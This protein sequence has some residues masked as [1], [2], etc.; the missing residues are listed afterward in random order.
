MQ[1]QV[2]LHVR[3]YVISRGDMSV[4]RLWHG[5]TFV[6]RCLPYVLIGRHYT[7]K[8][9]HG[10]FTLGYREGQGW[11]WLAYTLAIYINV[12]RSPLAFQLST[13]WCSARMASRNR[14]ISV[15]IHYSIVGSNRTIVNLLMH[16]IVEQALP[17]SIARIVQALEN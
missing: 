13:N 16:I 3:H 14:T 5:D 4:C 11:R 12:R 2:T 9:Q 10:G 17:P 8:D 1:F 7:T 6:H 15:G